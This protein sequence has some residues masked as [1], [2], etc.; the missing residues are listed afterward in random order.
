[1]TRHYRAGVAPGLAFIDDD[2][3]E[4][5]LD[6][7]DTASLLGIIGGFDAA[8]VSAC[9]DCRARVLA[10]VALVDLLE[11]S[12]PHP[13]AGDLRDLAEDAPT[14]HLFVVEA[15]E[16]CRHRRWRDPLAD[17]W[18]DVVGASRSPEARR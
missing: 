10:T 12:A 11:R 13:R 15:D 5:A 3:V 6:E 14:L 8:T 17:E 1:M 7:T 16:R 9:P 2:G 18:R 4:L